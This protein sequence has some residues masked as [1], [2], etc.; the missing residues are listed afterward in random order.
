MRFVDTPGIITT[1]GTGNDNRED[2]KTILRSEMEKQNSKLCLL[3]EPKEFQTNDIIN[4]CDET[5][6]GRDKWKDHAICLMNK[7]DQKMEDT[8]TA[9]RANGFFKTFHENGCFPFLVMTPTLPNENL[10]IHELFQDRQKLL[11]SADEKENERF[12][13]WMRGQETYR[14]QNEEHNEVI[15]AK[16]LDRI[17]FPAAKKVMRTI[18]LADTAKRLPEVIKKLREELGNREKEHREL[19]EKQKFTDPAQLAVVATDLVFRLQERVLAYLDG[20]L[21]TAKKYPERLQSLDE[22]IDEEEESDWAFKDLNHHTEKENQ[23][24]DNLLI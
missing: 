24:R 19:K 21:Q 1:Q 4:F 17:G 9:N 10:T 8:R 15:D 11:A 5:L 14:N 22:E 16:V 6:G 18:M 12:Q 23:W 2:I 3:L 20:D 13:S 7:F